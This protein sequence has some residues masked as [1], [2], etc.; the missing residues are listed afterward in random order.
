MTAQPSLI[1]SIIKKGVLGVVVGAVLV[2]LA[3]AL[4]FPPL[5]QVMFFTYAML[6]TV[7]FILLDAPSVK[8]IGGAK[9]LVY[10]ANVADDLIAA[11]LRLSFSIT[12]PGGRNG[13][14]SSGAR[15]RQA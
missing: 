4:A 7:V 2:G 5:F 1:K 10:A 14:P 3:K 8:P 9:A 13:A 6:G 12:F 11:T 15:D